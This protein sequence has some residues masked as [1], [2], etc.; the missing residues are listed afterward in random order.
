M[1]TKP[2]PWVN[3]ELGSLKGAGTNVGAEWGG[4]IDRPM[5]EDVTT[6][7][8]EAPSICGRPWLQDDERTWK[9]R[10]KK[11][12]ANVPTSQLGQELAFTHS[13]SEQKAGTASQDQLHTLWD[14]VQN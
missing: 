12:G 14:P 13:L 10:M 7:P 5:Q 8:R 4:A 11:P 3:I 1:F 9:C 6:S 2:L